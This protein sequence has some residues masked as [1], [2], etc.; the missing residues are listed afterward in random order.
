MTRPKVFFVVENP[1]S[2]RDW[3]RFGIE[4]LRHRFDLTVL[5][6]TELVHPRWWKRQKSVGINDLPTHAVHSMSDLCSFL[7]SSSPD[8]IIMNLGVHRVRH[9]F[10]KYAQRQSAITAEF[11]FGAIPGDELNFSL[12]SKFKLVL[13]KPTVAVRGMRAR[14]N[15]LRYGRDHPT[16]FFRG[17]KAAVSRSPLSKTRVVDAHSLDYET[18]HEI[19]MVGVSR[20]SRFDTPYVVYIDQ[21]LGYHPDYQQSGTKS[22]ITPN[23]FYPAIN[24]FFAEVTRQTGFDVVVAPHPRSTCTQNERLFWNAKISSDPTVELIADCEFV[25]AHYSTA[26]SFAVLY[27]KP[28][29]QITTTELLDSWENKFIAAYSNALGKSP[30]N[31]DDPVGYPSTRSLDLSVYPDFYAQYLLSFLS[32]SPNDHRRLWEIVADEI[33]AGIKS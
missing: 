29:V 32:S 33:E 6:V 27:S 21:N 23:C 16:L 10:Y 30:L 20:Q 9:Q 5:D 11:Q 7:N 14:I 25:L 24:E 3:K 8:A 28:I 22:P 18:F 31:I 26:I 4:I 12:R 15:R 17:G 13:S 1:F 19:N 2:E